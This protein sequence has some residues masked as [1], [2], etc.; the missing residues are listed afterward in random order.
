MAEAVQ[1]QHQR[2]ICH[3]DLKSN[4]VFVNVEQD[5]VKELVVADFGIGSERASVDHHCGSP[6][7]SS[8]SESCPSKSSFLG[9]L[10]G[11]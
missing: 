6:S 4:N 3:Q 1:A 2:K 7:E 11:G 8:P 10:S 9:T 5:E